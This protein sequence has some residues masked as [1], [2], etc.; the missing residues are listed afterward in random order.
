MAH[1]HKE[2]TTMIKMELRTDIMDR[3]NDKNFDYV[4][5]GRLNEFPTLWLTSRQK[6]V[7][8]SWWLAKRLADGEV[9]PAVV[10]NS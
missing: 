6:G 3:F 7:E 8:I 9:S 10:F 5:Y 2:V 1:E 4:L